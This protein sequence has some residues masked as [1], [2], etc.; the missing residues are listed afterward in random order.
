VKELQEVFELPAN[1]FNKS[2]EARS[3]YQLTNGRRKQ[4]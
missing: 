3:S 4:R 1:S 2:A